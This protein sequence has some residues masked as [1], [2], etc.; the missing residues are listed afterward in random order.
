MELNVRELLSLR[1]GSFISTE[2]QGTGNGGNITLKA[3]IVLGLENS[4]IIAN[5]KGGRGGNINITTQ[6]IIGLKFRN[7]RTPRI[8]ITN[9]ITA[10]SEFNIN[11]NVSINT[12][13]IN[14]TNALNALPHD[15]TDASRQITDRCASSKTGSFI[16]TGRGGIPKSPMQTRKSDR[17][18][19]D[20]RLSPQIQQ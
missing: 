16:S 20:L 1:H 9:D 12:I 2:A 11:G 17:T 10:S 13:D 6:G 18:W 14:P 15:I 7:T 3:P 8:D 4:D 5:A 19:H